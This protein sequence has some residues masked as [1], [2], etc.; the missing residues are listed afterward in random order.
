MSEVYEKTLFIC[1]DSVDGI[2]S[3]VY[4]AYASRLGHSRIKLQVRGP[5]TMELFC[6]YREVATDP[7]KAAKVRRSVCDKIS[8]KAW[9]YV[10][11]TALSSEASKA[12]DIYR[13]LVGGFY[14]GSKA[15]DMLT[16]P[17][18]SR[19]M[20]IDRA[21]HREAG[22][23]MEFLKFERISDSVLVSR[24]RP[25]ANVIPLI[26]HHFCDRMPDENFLIWDL[27]RNIAGVH[28]AVDSWYMAEITPAMSALLCGGSDEFTELWRTFFNAVAIREREN[29]SCQRSH[30]PLRFRSDLPEFN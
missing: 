4:E 11:R 8:F 12:D 24:I 14:F 30:I 15:M 18:V 2:L 10:Y 22:H 20:D 28:P 7:V 16:E 3:A 23:W 29:Y 6:G 25:K 21:V 27:N 26:M 17:A 5:V 9:S 1:E 13:F 19:I